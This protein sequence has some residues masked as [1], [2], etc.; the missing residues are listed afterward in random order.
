MRNAQYVA[1][2]DHLP[3][4]VIAI[5][6]DYPAHHLVTTHAHGRSQLLYGASGVMVVA[7]EHG[8]WVVPPERAVWLPAGQLHSV[9]ITTGPVS[10][11]SIYVLPDAAA[12]LPATC[13]V[14]GMLPLMR[15]LLLESADLPL[16]YDPRGRD[17]LVM[18]LLL[19]EIRRL[20]VQPLSL[21]FPRDR[22]LAHKCRRLLEEPTPHDTIDEFRI[23]VGMS[24][25]AFTRLFRAETGMSFAEWRQQACILAALPRL[26]SGQAVTTVALELGY[27]SPAAFTSMFK[28]MLG[29]PPS[30]YFR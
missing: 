30:R 23:E 5:G 9:Q 6:N 29:A 14:L 17:G 18:S 27:E 13:Q 11:R 20:P 8:V 1:A 26:A 24:R 4:K 3:H 15:S 28:R 25:R 16:D 12:G 21:P 10:T 19:E 2:F 7:T 22:R